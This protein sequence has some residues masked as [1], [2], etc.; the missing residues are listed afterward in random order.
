MGHSPVKAINQYCH[1]LFDL[2]LFNFED[3]ATWMYDSCI[4]LRVPH[5]YLET[6]SIKN[7]STS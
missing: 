1:F 7:S 4:F 6:Y 3:I 2:L 5:N